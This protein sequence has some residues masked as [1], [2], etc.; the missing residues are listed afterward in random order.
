MQLEL[1]S[2]QQLMQYIEKKVN[3]I[4]FYFFSSIIDF[5]NNRKYHEN[6]FD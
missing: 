5:Y 1:L 6:I 3:L 4:N 2:V